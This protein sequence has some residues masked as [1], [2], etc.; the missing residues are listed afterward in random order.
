MIALWYA[1]IHN[2]L[3][4]QRLREQRAQAAAAAAPPPPVKI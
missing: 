1:L 2:V 3:V 4:A